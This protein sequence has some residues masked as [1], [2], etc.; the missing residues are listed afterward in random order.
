MRIDEPVK[1]AL[2]FGTRKITYT[3]HRQDRKRMRIVVS[4]ELTV[5]VFTPFTANHEQI[6]AAVMK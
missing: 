6:E 1:K 4:P 2:T 3:L 5:D